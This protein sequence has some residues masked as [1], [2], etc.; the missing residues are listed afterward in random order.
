MDES[1]TTAVAAPDAE[2]RVQ[3]FSLRL[4]HCMK[5]AGLDAGAVAEA[6]GRSE[7]TV[8]GWVFRCRKVPPA[9]TVRRL[10]KLFGVPVDEVSGL[11]GRC[12]A[13]DASRLRGAVGPD[14]DGALGEV[15]GLEPG[16]L[17]AMGSGLLPVPDQL[18]RRVAAAAGIDPGKVMEP[19]LFDGTDPGVIDDAVSRIRTSSTDLTGGQ[20]MRLMD[21]LDEWFAHSS[22]VVVDIRPKGVA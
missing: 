21:A 9:P 16:L 1:V 22:V 15:L 13:L 14:W 19:R 8:E 7:K 20:V 18:A 10:S 12:R 2:R 6:T 11:K 17:R 3:V 4:A 5:V